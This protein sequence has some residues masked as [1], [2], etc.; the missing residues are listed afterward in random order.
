MMERD[1]LKRIHC[2]PES[3]QYNPHSCDKKG[4]EKR[5]RKRKLFV[6]LNHVWV[7][8]VRCCIHQTYRLLLNEKNQDRNPKTQFTRRPLACYCTDEPAPCLVP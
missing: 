1:A 3:T 4:I 7:Q 8:S 5:K 2:A 6:Q